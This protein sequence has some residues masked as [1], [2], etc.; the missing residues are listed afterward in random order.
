M[1][2]LCRFFVVALLAT[3][4][5]T[6]AFSGRVHALDVIVFE[7]L[8]EGAIEYGKISQRF[9]TCDVDPPYS[10]R[11]AFLKYAKYQGAGQQHLEILSK[12]FDEG[13]ARVRNLRSG[14]SPE[15]CKAKLDSPEGKK[16]LR[17]HSRMGR[18]GRPMKQVRIHGP[19]DVRVDDVDPIEPGHVT[20][21]SRWRR[22]GSA[23]ATSGT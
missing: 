3:L 6:V 2:S 8:K 19:G 1:P 9:V 12:V 15:E 18:E 7:E 10:V 22:V 23:E 4:S 20:W 16:L 21:S 17:R 13:A 5:A 11:T 14:F